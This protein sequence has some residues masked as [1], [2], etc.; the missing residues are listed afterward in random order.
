MS[1]LARPG[2]YGVGVGP[3]DPRWLTLRA[4]E[5]LR[6]ADVIALPRGERASA[7]R[8]LA[9]VG[10]LLDR[11]RQHF[12][13][14]PFA[15]T[16][17][18]EAA[19]AS[20]EAIYEMVAAAL[21]AGRAVACPLL[22]DPLL[23]GSFGHLL[24]RVRERLP[25]VPVEI[26]PGVTAFTAAAARAG[27]PL[28]Q[29]DERL[30]ILPAVYEGDL[31]ALRDTLRRFDTTVLLKINRCVDEVLDVLDELD[32]TGAAWYAEHVGMAEERF[33][34]DVRALRG[35]DLPYFSLLVVRGRGA[36]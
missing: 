19:E 16:G 20:R 9:I 30:A 24:A 12:L 5:V 18:A 29:G 10:E 23:Y 7:S 32:L 27:R 15:T 26:V 31:A 21:A 25:A 4:A 13:E 22:G 1:A 3:G 33:A 14:L 11:G 36:R 17:G 8:T 35:R 34:P 2:L 28:V 6:E